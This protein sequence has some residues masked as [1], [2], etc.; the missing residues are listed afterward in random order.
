M[1]EPGTL[2][3]A[4]RRVKKDRVDD[5]VR[6][7]F[8]FDGLQSRRKDVLASVQELLESDGGYECGPVAH[9]RVP[10]SPYTTRPGALLSPLDRI[11]YHWLVDQMYEVLE[12]HF[13]RADDGVVF[14]YRYCGDPTSDRPVGGS[15]TDYANAAYAAALEGSWVITTDLV[16]YFERVDHAVLSTCLTGLGVQ[17]EVVSSAAKLLQGWVPSLSCG[18]PQSQDPSGYLGSA[19]LVS[20]D[21]SAR[22]RASAYCRYT[23][24]MTVVLP[25]RKAALEWLEQSERQ[26]WRLGLALNCAK[27][28]LETMEEYVTTKSADQSKLERRVPAPQAAQ[29]AASMYGS[30]AQDAEE[31]DAM[32]AMVNDHD[33]FVDLFLDEVK[34]PNP[35]TKLLRMCLREFASL[36]PTGALDYV[37]PNLAAC[38]NAGTSLE[39]CLSAARRDDPAS[40]DRIAAVLALELSNSGALSHAQAMWALHCC[41]RTPAS[42]P[43]LA[44]VTAGIARSSRDW[45]EPVGAYAMLL[46]AWDGGED[47]KRE[48][49]ISA[50][51]DGRPW[52]RYGAM[53]GVQELNVAERNAFLKRASKGDPLADLLTTSVK[54]GAFGSALA[55]RRK[56]T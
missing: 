3:L 29:L 35:S 4:W 48:V 24:D 14:S 9:L 53:A 30:G 54:Q 5:L 25:S 32:L 1:A 6:G 38:L 19:F 36:N 46:A 7:D 31:M 37:L 42:S 27:T 43:Q 45:A 50:E 39:K 15:Y 16:R 49:I 18:L 47:T 56:V 17:R 8:V 2:E 23:D 33:A 11:V 28:R 55:A 52:V 40:A 21:R 10:K 12:P 13:P 20:F 51:R 34:T 26:L 41:Y 22:N 44:E